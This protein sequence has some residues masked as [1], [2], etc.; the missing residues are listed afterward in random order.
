[1]IFTSIRKVDSLAEKCTGI[2]ADADSI[3]AKW[4]MITVFARLGV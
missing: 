3:P 2:P 4:P 1:M